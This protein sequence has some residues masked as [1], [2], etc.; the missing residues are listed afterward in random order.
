MDS[1]GLE[2]GPITGRKEGFDGYAIRTV[3]KERKKGPMVLL[4]FDKRGKKRYV[5]TC[6]P[7]GTWDL[8]LL[9]SG[10]DLLDDFRS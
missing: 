5:L 3:K 8:D 10:G 7:I 6:N 1:D 4:L 2:R 9:V